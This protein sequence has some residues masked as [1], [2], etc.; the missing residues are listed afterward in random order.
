MRYGKD[1]IT[2]KDKLLQSPELIKQ[3]KRDY[4]KLGIQPLAIKYGVQ[5]YEINPILLELNIEVKPRKS[6]IWLDIYPRKVNHYL[7]DFTILNKVWERAT[8]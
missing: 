8:N 6:E 1:Y 2:N 3:F 4:K 7:F 5:T